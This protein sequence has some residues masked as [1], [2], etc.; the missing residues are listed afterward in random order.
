M[1]NLK[2]FKVDKLILLVSIMRKSGNRPEG[3]VLRNKLAQILQETTEININQCINACQT[4]FTNDAEGF[5]ERIKNSEVIEHLQPLFETNEFQTLYEET[6]KYKEDVISRWNIAKP[7]VNQYF[8]QVLGIV[9]DKDIVVNIVHPD[10][11]TGTNNMKNEIYYGHYESKSNP[12]CDPVWMMHESLHCMFPYKKE[13]NKEQISICHS[14]IELATDN[15]LLGIL[16]E[17]NKFYNYGH[18][19]AA[20]IREQL[21]PIWDKFVKGKIEAKNFLELMQYCTENYKIVNE[22]LEVDTQ[23]LGQETM[24][25]QK[26]IVYINETEKIMGNLEHAKERG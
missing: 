26:D 25:E 4:F 11:N 19:D 23:K 10:F 17:D 22:S 18:N 20:H 21:K 13:W 7:K 8:S 16:N 15:E 12:N 1:V 9:E 6:L 2:E 3:I 14:L 24:S 5:I